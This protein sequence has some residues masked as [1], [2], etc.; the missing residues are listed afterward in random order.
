MINKLYFLDG[1]SASVKFCNVSTFWKLD[2]FFLILTLVL[3]VAMNVN[4]PP[5][6]LASYVFFVDFVV[7]EPVT[8]SASFAKKKKQKDIYKI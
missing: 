3:L 4:L 8:E 1:L 2:F 5:R 7:P 6:C